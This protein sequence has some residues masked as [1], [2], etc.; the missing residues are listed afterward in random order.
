MSIAR[1]VAKNAGFIVIGNVGVRFIALFVS[2]Y[3]ARYLGVTNF[4]TY[5]FVTT[6]LIFFTFIGN[7][8]LDQVIIRDIARDYSITNVIFSDAFFIRIAT[9]IVAMLLAII[10]IYFLNY[11][12]ETIF[13]VLVISVTLLFQ[14]LSSL[15]ESLFQ[16]YLKMEYSSIAVIVSK[17]FF[18]LFIFFIIFTKGSLIQILFAFVISEAARTLISYIYSKKFVN[19]KIDVN[20]EMWS[21]LLKESLPF[22]I[23][24]GLYIIYYR[25]DVLMLSVLQ[26]DTSVGFYS[27]AYKLTDPLLFLPGALASTLMP[28][29]SKQYISEK[30]KL[31]STYLMSVKYIVTLMLPIVIGIYLLSE[32]IINLL[33]GPSFSGSIVSLQILVGTI[34]FNSLNSIQTSL[35]TSANRQKVTTLAIGACCVLN[36]ILN[37]VLIPNY[38]YIGASFATL[39]SVIA[40]FFIEFFFVYKILFIHYV[41]KDLIKPVIASGIMG[42]ILIILPKINIFMMILAGIIVYTVSIFVFRIFSKSDLELFLKVVKR[43]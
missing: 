29:M 36:V 2:I 19:I 20:F 5:T 12:A 14:G 15:I 1:D 43:N 40:L 41:N 25:I 35:L 17:V 22:V 6:Y 16:S 33:Y 7:F 32:D 31:K 28:I 27:A 37:S 8:G 9:S 23:G 11:P 4:G 26:G 13:Y 34:I 18:A 39:V 21:Y 3:L 24:Y 42:L 38:S 30:H 10:G